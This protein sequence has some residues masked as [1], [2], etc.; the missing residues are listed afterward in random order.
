[1]PAVS[2]FFQVHQPFRL[3]PYKFFDIGSGR[4][5]VNTYLNEEILDRVADKCYLPANHMMLDLINQTKGAFSVAFSISGTAL[6]QFEAYRP[7]VLDSFKELAATGHVRFLGETYY[8]SLSFFYDRKEFVRQ[9]ERHREAIEN[10][11]DQKPE[12]FRNTELAC[13]NDLLEVIEQHGFKGIVT[14]GLEWF[15]PPSIGHPNTVYKGV[16]GTETRILLRNH[17]LSNDVGYRYT[18]QSWKKY[19]LTARK[20]V[21]WL[22]KEPGEVVNLYMD[23]E[24]IGEHHAESSGIFNF[25]REFGQKWSVN[26][27]FILPEDS[28]KKIPAKTELDIYSPISWADTERDLSAWNGNPL[29]KAALKRLYELGDM[30]RPLQ[31]KEMDD[32]WSVLQSSDH[33]YYMST[34]QQHDGK[35]HSYF[36]PYPTPYDAYVYFM[37]VLSDFELRARKMIEAS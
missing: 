28:L 22:A 31:N 9:I 2:L 23:Y 8:H 24:T 36:S 35:V 29:Q 16:G 34:K 4:E 12:I 25:F 37:N 32:L 30:I 15:I 3:Y 18:D 19:P 7:D 5:Y 21:N 17:H 13:Q 26:E 1:M 20:Y 33:F 10:H 27:G 11:F 14:E 6:E